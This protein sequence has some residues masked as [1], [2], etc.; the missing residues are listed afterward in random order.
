MIQFVRNYDDLSTEKGFQ[1]SFH[2]DKC[3][4]G[5]MSQY[6][7]NSLGLAGDLLNA[8]SSVFGG[9]F[10]EAGDVTRQMQRAIGGKAH[11]GALQKAVQEAKAHFHQCTRCGKWVCPEVCWNAGAGLCE[12]CAPDEHE[13]L[14]A[15]QALATS[16]QITKKTREA[17]YTNH[18]DFS[19]RTGVSECPACHTKLTA[20]DKFCP[21]CGILNAKGVQSEK[22]CSNCGTK[23]KAGQKFCSDCGTGLG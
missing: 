17:D 10:S 23:A 7:S 8:A 6:Q 18:I 16:E 15:Q 13:E 9:F 14:A 1:F 19:Q 2:C 3:G 12:Y 20:T 11:D 22:F 21:T 5:Y 4:N